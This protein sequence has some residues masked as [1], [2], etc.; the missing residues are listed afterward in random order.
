[1]CSCINVQFK[2]IASMPIIIAVAHQKGGVGKS[3]LA[4]NLSAY[5]V[6]NG[7]NSAVVD[8][9][10]QGSI[11]NLVDTFGE[12]DAFGSIRLIPRTAYDRFEELKDRPEDILF[13]DTPPY[14]ST[15]LDDIFLNSDYVLVPTKISPLD[16]LAIEATIELL[17]DVKEKKPELLVGIV[18]NLVNK[19]EGFLEHIKEHLKGRGVIIQDTVIT[20]RTEFQRSFLSG[21]IF[22][23]PDKKAQKEIAELA[24]D[25]LMKLEGVEQETIGTPV[26]SSVEET[27]DAPTNPVEETTSKSIV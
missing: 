18:I 25:I 26:E 1:M 22:E 8:A 4:A 6:K 23:S 19:S 21:S 27:A 12:N 9:D 14:L 17:D 2:N 3:T 20:K 10:I 13:I 11:T 24:E 16:M 7:T 15:D 5:F